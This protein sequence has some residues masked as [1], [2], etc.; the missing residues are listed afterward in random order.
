MVLLDERNGSLLAR[1]GNINWQIDFFS[2]G[3][4]FCSLY[5]LLNICSGK[6]RLFITTG[7]LE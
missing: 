6:E 4:D 3:K 2:S 5:V 7:G 1:V